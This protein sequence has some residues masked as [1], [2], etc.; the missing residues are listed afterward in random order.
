MQYNFDERI[1]EER[2]K[3]WIRGKLLKH[4]EWV[5][6]DL[7]SEFREKLRERIDLEVGKVMATLSTSGDLTI[8]L[9]LPN[10]YEED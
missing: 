9:Q 1:F 4:A 6:E 7:V 10:E 2:F 8:T 5:I 3:P